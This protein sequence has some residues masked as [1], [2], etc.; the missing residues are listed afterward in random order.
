MMA[1]ARF[2]ILALLALVAGLVIVPHAQAQVYNRFGPANGVLVGDTSTYNTTAAAASDV[3]SLWSGTCNASSFLRGD[4]SCQIVASGP[5]PANPTA[6]VGLTAVN[7]VAT[8]YTRS[9]GS[10]ALDQSIAPTWTG[11]HTFDAAYTNFTQ[12]AIDH[13]GAAGN[14]RFHQDA[15]NWYIQQCD[16]LNTDCLD[17]L[18]FSATG[19]ETIIGS[20][21]HTLINSG[22][23]QIDF[24][25]SNID[26]T[27]PSGE[28]R[29]NRQ[30]EGAK[31]IC[32]QDGTNCP[33]S[34]GSFANPTAVIGLT[35]VNGVLTS[36]LRSDGAPALS[37]A[38]V[39]TWSGVHTFAATPVLNT[40]IVPDA[41][42]GATLGTSTL[43]FSEVH[44]TNYCEG[45]CATTRFIDSTGTTARFGNGSTWTNVLLPK[46]T[47]VEAG[48]TSATLM[49]N[50]TAA[51]TNQ[52][53][54]FTSQG[55]SQGAVCVSGAAGQCVTGDADGDL[56]VR[57]KSG[58]TLRLS[59]N[60][61]AST[62]A[63]LNSSNVFNAIGGLQVNGTNVC[64]AN[65]TN[66]LAS[67]PIN[68]RAA[69]SFAGSGGTC[70]NAAG[71]PQPVNINSC[72][73]SSAG[74]Y[75]VNM[76]VP[77]PSAN[78]FVCAASTT[79]STTPFFT[80]VN[81]INSQ[82]VGVTVRNS[83]G[84]ATDADFNIVCHGA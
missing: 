38:I 17:K 60:D 67:P 22:S 66:C 10:P 39:P 27:T 51:T 32:L 58:N 57:V 50:G 16:T 23:G 18:T 75:V 59:T 80:A 44:S 40:A 26:L 52:I 43:R 29:V 24:D 49:V 46:S 48:G 7:G 71:T 41:D 33:A 31:N 74:V 9:D 56:A 11:I 73:R 45:D 14:W 15:S 12:D 55:V 47:T 37:Q 36:G 3:I 83:A 62:G 42:V 19:N 53:L 1:F 81:Y 72:S 61:G 8:T 84:T 4:G 13:T 77:A 21:G 54:L 30:G 76:S 35:A 28:V 69:G 34:G 63:S 6:L 68:T 78:G 79:S 5:S 20:S 2:R 82:S 25:A 70:T 65:G 64:L